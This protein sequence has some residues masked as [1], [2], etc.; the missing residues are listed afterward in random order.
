[1]IDQAWT[2]ADAWLFGCADFVMIM[3]SGEDRVAAFVQEHRRRL[4]VGMDGRC[5][6][7][8]DPPP[9]LHLQFNQPPLDGDQSARQRP[10]QD[11]EDWGSHKLQGGSSNSEDAGAG[12]GGGFAFRAPLDAL[13]GITEEAPFEL[14]ALEVTL[15][16]RSEGKSLPSAQPLSCC[17]SCLTMRGS[18]APTL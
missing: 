17:P 7:Q 6:V 15:M 9:S 13:P 5:I 14:R 12:G 1:M 10:S 16:C 4:R 2:A 18:Q 8:T 3:D 11:P